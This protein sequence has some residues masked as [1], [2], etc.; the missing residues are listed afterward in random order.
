MGDP[1]SRFAVIESV[2]CLECGSIYPRAGAGGRAAA[3]PCCPDCGY[4]GWIPAGVPAPEG[5][6]RRPIWEPRPVPSR[7]R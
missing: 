7:P 2:R 5:V 4:A 6:P 1:G 3:A